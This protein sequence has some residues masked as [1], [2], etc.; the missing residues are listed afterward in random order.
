MIDQ[1]ML[2]TDI[3]CRMGHHGHS[4]ATIRFYRTL[5]SV[6]MIGT[7]AYYMTPESRLSSMQAGMLRSR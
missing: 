3:Y 6:E 1:S 2:C 7:A 4:S 5:S